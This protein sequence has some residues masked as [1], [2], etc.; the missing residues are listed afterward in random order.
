MKMTAIAVGNDSTPTI[1]GLGEDGKVYV[2][3]SVHAT[4]SLHQTA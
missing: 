2:W 3:D 1:F 4:W